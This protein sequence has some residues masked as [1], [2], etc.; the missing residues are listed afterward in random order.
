MNDY[1]M[2]GT[3]NNSF[4]MISLRRGMII[5]LVITYKNVNLYA[6]ENNVAL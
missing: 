6:T 3:K 5:L 4:I 1:A 2:S